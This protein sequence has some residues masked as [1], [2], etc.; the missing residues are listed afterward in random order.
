[1]IAPNR[2]PDLSP[3]PDKATLVIMRD[4]HV[5]FALILHHYVDGKFIGQT[6]GK[7]YFVTK[8]TP[9]KHY[10]IVAA[11]NMAVY[12]IDFQPGR[13]YYLCEGVA[14]PSNTT[15]LAPMKPPQIKEALRDCTY[16]EIDPQDRVSDMDSK[17]YQ[18]VVADYHKE[19]KRNPE[20]FKDILHYQGTDWSPI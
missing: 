1:M 13:I 5:C 7:T 8:V 15:G 10:V 2:Q 16:L 12:Q 14:W 17:V 19:L 6:K 20:G 11:G 3:G 9:G 18:E 4:I